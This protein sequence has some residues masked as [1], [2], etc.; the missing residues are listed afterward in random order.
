MEMH[1]IIQ[2]FSTF[3]VINSNINDLNHFKCEII[4]IFWLV[5]NWTSH[6]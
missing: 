5:L 2:E 1:G 6:E 3:L 4:H